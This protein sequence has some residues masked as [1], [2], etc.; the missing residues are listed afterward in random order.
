MVQYGKICSSLWQ[1]YPSLGSFAKTFSKETVSYLEYQ[2]ETWAR[3]IPKDLRLARMPTVED[4]VGANRSTQRLRILLHVRKNHLALLVNRHCVLSAASIQRDLETATTLI[5]T[6]KNTICVLVHFNNACSAYARQQPAYNHFLMTA[7]AIV[8]LAVCHAPREFGNQ[9]RPAF[10]SAMNLVRTSAARGSNSRRLWK[11]IRDLLPR[12]QE[13]YASLRSLEGGR[14]TETTSTQRTWQQSGSSQHRAPDVTQSSVDHQQSTWGVDAAPAFAN[15]PHA[16]QTLTTNTSGLEPYS[17]VNAWGLPAVDVPPAQDMAQMTD[18][19]TE[20]Y[21]SF[22][23]WDVE[24]HPFNFASDSAEYSL[25]D[26]ELTR[27][28]QEQIS[29]I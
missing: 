10:D 18:H 26:A 22:E 11:S 27:L 12:A 4:E 13:L 1:S 20:L 3:S 14:D 23:T 7:L 17:A 5:E 19:L 16:V 8:F 21:E 9:C 24:R 15:P 29:G 2:I 6:A 25:N 28:F